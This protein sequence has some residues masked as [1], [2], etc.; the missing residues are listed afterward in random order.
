MLLILTV[1]PLQRKAFFEGRSPF[2]KKRR[3]SRHCDQSVDHT[4]F[5]NEPIRWF[6][7]PPTGNSRDQLVSSS[8][9][10][11]VRRRNNGNCQRGD[12]K[13]DQICFPRKHDS[14]KTDEATINSL[15]SQ[16]SNHSFKN[17][18]ITVIKSVAVVKKRNIGCSKREYI[19]FW[20]HSY[21]RGDCVTY[22][23]RIWVST[24]D[25]ARRWPQR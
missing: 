7:T 4:R 3:V 20:T 24:N 6:V 8:L 14:S 2:P 21:F 19:C 12:V 16:G 13:C 22:Q 23:Q 25:T 11:L 10:P 1:S 5:A 18:I 15:N 17:R 9:G